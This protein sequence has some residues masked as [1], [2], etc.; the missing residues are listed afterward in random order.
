MSIPSPPRASVAA[1]LSVACRASVTADTQAVPECSV[2]HGR[3]A[4]LK[5]PARSIDDFGAIE[6]INNSSIHSM[7]ILYPYISCLRVQ[8][9]LEAGF[10]RRSF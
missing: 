7:V 5:E 2:D 10:R 9:F 8:N 3:A 6:S 4:Q 1:R